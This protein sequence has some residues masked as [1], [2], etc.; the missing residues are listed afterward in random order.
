[1]MF[2][3]TKAV[4]GVQTSLQALDRYED[5]SMQL[6]CQLTTVQAQQRACYSPKVAYQHCMEQGSAQGSL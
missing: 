6:A 2:A 1:M 3:L 5:V 4:L